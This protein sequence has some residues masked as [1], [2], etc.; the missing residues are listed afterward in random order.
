MGLI[1]LFPFSREVNSMQRLALVAGFCGTLMISAAQAAPEKFFDNLAGNWS[2]SGSAYVAMFG[3]I[4]ANCRLAVTGANTKVSMN[5]SCGLLLFRQALGISLQSAGNNKYV[6]TYTGSK[7]GPA[8]LSGT[9]R[10]N[11]LVMS[12]WWA[13]LV[14]GDRSAQMVLERTGPDSFAQ[15]VSDKVAGINRNTSSFTFKRR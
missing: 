7:T 8:A 6:G 14:N 3:D 15:S 5:G 1:L 12:I 13:G 11:R 9:L 2:G 10:G 4:S